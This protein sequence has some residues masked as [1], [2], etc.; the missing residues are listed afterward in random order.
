MLIGFRKRTAIE[1]ELI[2]C[3]SDCDR[4]PAAKD[5]VHKAQRRFGLSTLLRTKARA[6]YTN[7]MGTFSN[8]LP[9]ISTSALMWKLI[10]MDLKQSHVMS[11]CFPR[12]GRWRKSCVLENF[13]GSN[14]GLYL[15]L[16]SLAITVYYI[17]S[18]SY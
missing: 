17:S 16:L 7:R 9:A 14:P 15:I 2:V 8:K 12:L 13:T 4:A 10:S 1:L 6:L 3:T 11:S 18:R 5:K